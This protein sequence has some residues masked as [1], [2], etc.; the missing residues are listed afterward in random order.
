M[1]E[2][3]GSDGCKTI[4]RVLVCGP[5]WP[6]STVYTKDYLQNYPFIQVDEVGLKEVPG[7]IQNYHIC[8]ARNRRMDS[9][10]IA[11]ATQMKIIMQN[12]VG[13]EGVDIGAAT[14]HNIKV[15]R[16]PGCTTGNAIACAEMTI[17]LTLGVLR[18]QKEMDRAV[19]Q[20]ELGIPA[21]ETIYGRTIFIMGFGAI[22][23][24]L[25]K[26][27]RVFGVKILSTKRNWSSKTVPCDIEVLVDKKGGLEDMYEFAGE[28]DIVITCMETVNT[29]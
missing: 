10:I 16:I 18:K 8:I 13:L 12:G 28:A 20:G 5:Y 26:R 27:L 23:Y 19:N 6:D 25:A 14:E 24:E 3:M 21:G 1:P 17:Y 29:L 9:D 22:G 2:A 7:V 4:T 15:T 11:R